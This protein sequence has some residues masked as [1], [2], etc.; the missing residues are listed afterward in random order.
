MFST[1]HSFACLFLR[2]TFRSISGTNLNLTKGNFAEFAHSIQ[3]SCLFGLWKQ[4]YNVLWGSSGSFPKVRE[5]NPYVAFRVISAWAWRPQIFN[6][7]CLHC[8]L[9]V[10][11]LPGREGLMK[12]T[13]ITTLLHYV[14][15]FGAWPM[16]QYSWPFILT[17][18]AT[19]NH[20]RNFCCGVFAVSLGGGIPSSCNHFFV[21]CFNIKAATGQLLLGSSLQSVMWRQR[22]NQKLQNHG[23]E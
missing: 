18:A 12:H 5:N 7:K 17:S 8:K 16:L 6:M 15:V 22:R 2:H 10:W 14:D 13:S 19:V 3:C 9:K 23:Y 1:L 21:D 11:S 4:F 20:M